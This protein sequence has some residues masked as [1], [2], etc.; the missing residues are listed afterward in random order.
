[1]DIPALSMSMATNQVQT[2]FGIAMLAKTL[3]TVDETSASMAK[4]MEQSVNPEIGGNI[5]ISL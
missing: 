2:E 5:D 3:D 4:M 1:M